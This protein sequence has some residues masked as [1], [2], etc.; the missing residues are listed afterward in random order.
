MKNLKKFLCV[1][2][3]LVMIFSIA[4]CGKKEEPK[5]DV[6]TYTVLTEAT[7]PPFES[8]DTDGKLVGVDID[9]IE[10]IAE[11][12]GF[13]V[14]WQDIAFDSLIPAIQS[15][16]G[17]IIAAFM[18]KTPVRMEKV[19]F[20]EG[21]YTGG[22]SLIV[23]EGNDKIKSIDDLTP[24]MVVASQM[25]TVEWN[26]ANELKEAG[27]IKDVISN[28][29]FVTCVMQ[30][31]NGEIDATLV[32][33]ITSKAYLA[34]FPGKIKLVDFEESTDAPSAFAVKKGNT[35]L[36]NMLDEGLKHIKENGKYDEIILKW[37]D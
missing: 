17:D 14:V 23:K 6:K 21:Y 37:V 25:G 32:G 24:D 26:K 15:D 35:E 19:D 1:V 5:D 34:K 12:Q 3:V 7:Y 9:L 27:K 16:Q 36:L 29:D 10:A 28:N 20:T 31:I 33:V 18:V 30:T 2:L 11:D 22:Y 13:K 8:Y 4:A